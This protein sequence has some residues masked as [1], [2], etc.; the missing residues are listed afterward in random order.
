VRRTRWFAL[1]CAAAAALLG[2]SC[3]LSTGGLEDTG[4]DASVPG[5]DATADS[6]TTF[7]TGGFTDTAPGDTAAESSKVDA[8][9][10][11]PAPHDANSDSMPVE[12]GGKCMGTPTSCG[13]PGSCVDCTHSA[14]GGACV[15]GACGCNG[16]NDCPAPTAC[17]AN[18]VC[19]SP[20]GG[21]QG[22]CNGGCCSFFSCVAFDNGHCGGSCTPCG[23]PTPTCGANG[24]CNGNCGGP[25]D[26]TCQTS[27][28]SN[29][30]C[31][32][33]G[34]QT[35]GDWGSTCVACSAATGG[36]HCKLIGVDY[37]CGCDGP[38]SPDQ[39]PVGDACHNMLC[40]SSCDGQHPCNGGCCSGNVIAT[41]TCVAGCDGGLNCTGSYCQ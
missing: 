16:S 21:G 26:G 19:G 34:D 4:G 20:C 6:T 5:D 7:D 40:S 9:L 37:Q 31:A 3:G 22:P 23:G 13:P 12:D 8:A 39:C 2:A 24:M 32:A 30:T 41:S 11:S 35:C 25:G 14:S 10:D 18:K 1:S 36:A 28:C 17:Q 27:C 33:I 15:K 38:G 29:G